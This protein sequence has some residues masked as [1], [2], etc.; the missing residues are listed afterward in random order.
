M[1]CFLAIELP[2]PARRHL[3]RVQGALRDPPDDVARASWV[4][5]ENWHVTLKFLGERADAEVVR[6]C[7]A[8]RDVQA[9]PMTLCAD[10]MV[11]F[12]RRGPVRVIAVE[13]GGDA[14]HLSGLHE[15]IEDACA[16][17]GLE[18]DARRFTGHITLGRSRNG[19][20]GGG[21]MSLRSR[22]LPELFPGTPF[23]VHD[24]ALMQSDLH[25]Q[26]ARYTR[27]ATFPLRNA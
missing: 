17:V 21:F 11:Y 6:I 1:R 12:P 5:R 8:L 15:A 20:R 26:G 2:E 23:D 7:E 4:R 22:T 27:L 13:V 24:F 3:A 14:G 25:P 10:R 16:S 19:E 9:E 18:R